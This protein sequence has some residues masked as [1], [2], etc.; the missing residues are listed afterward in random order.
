M[1][2]VLPYHKERE[3]L[4]LSLRF[5]NPDR[6]KASEFVTDFKSKTKNA[7]QVETII[8]EYSFN[9]TLYAVYA[10]CSYPEAFP[11]DWEEGL[12]HRDIVLI[13]SV[14]NTFRGIQNQWEKRGQPLNYYKRPNPRG[15][16]V[17]LDRVQ[18]RQDVPTTGGEI[19]SSLLLK[20]TLPNANHRTSVAYLRTYLQSMTDDSDAE[21]E[22]AGNYQGDWHEWAR[23]HI[24][25]SKRL[26]LLRR[27]PGL[28]Q[29]AKNQGVEIIRR[30]SGLEIDLSAQNFG[31]DDIQATAE[32]RHRN[33]CIQFTEDL[34]ER[35]GHEELKSKT[36]DGKRTFADRLS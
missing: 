32:A 13:D 30:K 16:G 8:E 36:D 26:L 2:N 7:V 33:R 31:E 20:H 15:I 28:L 10:A 5:I 1:P 6:D 22:H 3:D 11:K 17:A 19:M 4:V 25:E 21:F 34:L 24:Y 29:Y 27:K 23:N 18:W 12:S 35:S 9:S 14:I